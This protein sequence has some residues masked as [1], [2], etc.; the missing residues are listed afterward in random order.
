MDNVGNSYGRVEYEYI[1]KPDS[2]YCYSW[3]NTLEDL[4]TIAGYS[5][6]A[7]PTGVMPHKHHENGLLLQESMYDS[8][9]NL[10]NKRLNEYTIDNA[11]WRIIWGIAKEYRNINFDNPQYCT[12][13]D[14]NALRQNPAIS[15]EVINGNGIPMGYVYP[16][17]QPTFIS[18]QKSIN[19]KY[20][21]DNPIVTSKSYSYAPGYRNIVKKETVSLSDGN[22]IETDYY[23]P[24]DFDDSVMRQT[25]L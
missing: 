21:N 14:I 1:N 13:E 23:Y 20:E 18:L 19:T 10:I 11:Q 17:I 22:H 9:G 15:P 6:D 3:E 2:N 24:F 4:G 8:S 25:T 12:Q 7:N 16:A 5:V